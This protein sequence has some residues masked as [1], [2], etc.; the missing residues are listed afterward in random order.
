MKMS[1][2]ETIPYRRKREGK[3]NYK[4]RL[5]YL[6]SGTARLVIRKTNKQL[7]L[8][9]IEYTPDGDKIICG[10]TSNMLAKFGWNYGFVN[11]PACYLSGILI[12]KKAKEKKISSAIPDLGL[13]SNV[14]GSRIYAAIKGAIDG[15]LA[16]PADKEVLPSADRLSGKHIASYFLASGPSQFSKY[17]SQ[18]HDPA[19]MGKELESVKSKLMH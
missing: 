5:T 8:Q 3:T 7:I 17:K 14:P 11:I 4:K 13:Q 10:I 9:I 18:K 6:K 16:V 12:A 1:V 2:T 15:G 19:E